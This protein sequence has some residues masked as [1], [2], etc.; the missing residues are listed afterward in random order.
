M[1]RQGL[2]LFEEYESLLLDDAAFEQALIALARAPGSISGGVSG[3]SPADGTGCALRLHGL[4][5]LLEVA[6]EM[7]AEAG[8]H[9]VLAVFRAVRRH[10]SARF[11]R[12]MLWKTCHL[13]GVSLRGGLKL[14]EDVHVHPQHEKFVLSLWLCLHLR[15]LERGRETVPAQHVAI[16]RSALACVLQQLQ[17]AHAHVVSHLKKNNFFACAAGN[18]RA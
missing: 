12:S 9:N 4:F 2:G 7:L 8:L 17:G 6:V 10:A 3:E 11:E 1:S 5:V 16:Y 15:E 14:S 18:E 13:S